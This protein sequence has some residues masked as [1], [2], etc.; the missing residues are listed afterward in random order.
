ME[1][2]KSNFAAEIIKVPKKIVCCN[3]SQVT[4]W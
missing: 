2:K 4:N 3:E 1:T